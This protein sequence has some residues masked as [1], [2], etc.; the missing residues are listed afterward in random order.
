MVL[1]VGYV[2]RY[3]STV[4]RIASYAISVPYIAQHHT[5]S[6]YRASHSIVG[7]ES[8]GRYARSTRG[9]HTKTIRDMLVTRMLVPELLMPATTRCPITV[10]A[11]ASSVP[12]IAY[13]YWTSHS[14]R[15][16]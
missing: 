8:I 6:Q 11:C 7:R 4:H 12:D 9:A 2:I 16:G 1:I 3:L 5:L 15:V 13:E 10:A 14:E